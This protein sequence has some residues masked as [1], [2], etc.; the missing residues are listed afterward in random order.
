MREPFGKRIWLFLVFPCVMLQ[1]CLAYHPKPLD[2]ASAGRVLQA[3]NL[4]RL[5]VEARQL[6]HPLLAPVELNL[7]EGISPEAAAVLAVLASPSL[8][9]ARAKRGVAA[10]QL[11]QAGLLPNPQFAYDWATPTGG[12]TAGTI[13][14]FGLSLSWDLAA[15]VVRGAQIDAA[16][17]GAASVDLDIAWQEWQG[18]LAAKTHVY[19]LV[20]LAESL[21][22]SRKQEANLRENLDT[23]KKAFDLGFVTQVD[24]SAAQVALQKVHASGLVLAQQYEQ[25]RLALNQSIGF[26]PREVIALRPG[27]ILPTVETAP[28]LDE[29][30]KGIEKRRLDLVALRLGYESQEARVRAAVRAQFPA[31]TLGPTYARDTTNVI[32]TGFSVGIAIPLFNRNHGQIAIEE[33][34]REQ[35]YN[36]YLARLY[37]ARASIAAAIANIASVEEQ[38]DAAEEAIPVAQKL[39]E[40][41]RIALLEGHADVLT[42]YNALDSLYARQ[43]E[44][45]SLRKDLAGQIISLEV[46]SGRFLANQPSKGAA[47]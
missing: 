14:A 5:T 3:P 37:D 41:Y 23:T 20:F 4:A 2:Q 15:L 34:T 30:M 17:A 27:T 16:R 43:V 11:L 45:L 39:V 13:N 46:A 22:T 40:T 29:F 10:S 24:L 32:T 8:Q 21:A 9:A 44:L 1:G 19:N 36:E 31:L 12:S 25:E 42:Y 38:V 28:D 47:G 33:A 7:G 35:L 6:N 26:P 18:A